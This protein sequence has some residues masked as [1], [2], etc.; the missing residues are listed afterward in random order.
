MR[1]NNLKRNFKKGGY[2]F[3]GPQ[4]ELVSRCSF[5]ATTEK[6]LFPQQGKTPY[7]Y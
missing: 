1:K 5:Y 7:S 2:L 6:A 4:A 3:P